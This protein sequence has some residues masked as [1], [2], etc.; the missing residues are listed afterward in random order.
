MWDAADCSACVPPLLPENEDTERVYFAVQDQYIMSSMGGPVAINQLAIHEA[1]RLYDVCDPVD[2]FD[3]VVMLSRHFI[4]KQ[5][6]EAKA[7]QK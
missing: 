3:K 7:N 6:M 1:M 4:D 2:T 5:N